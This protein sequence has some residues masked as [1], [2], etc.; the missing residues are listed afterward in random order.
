MSDRDSQIQIK[1]F[2]FISMCTE[3]SFGAHRASAAAAAHRRVKAKKVI[4][5]R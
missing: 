1:C 3:L 4:L 2:V 5:S